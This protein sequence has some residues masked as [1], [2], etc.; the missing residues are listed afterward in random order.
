L[1]VGQIAVAL[2]VLAGASL[3]VKSLLR[4][5]QVDLGFDSARLL[6][7]G[8]ILP[9]SR[10]GNWTADNTR[11]IDAQRRLLER[12]AAIPGVEIV[13]DSFFNEFTLKLTVEARPA[14]PDRRGPSGCQNFRKT[15]EWA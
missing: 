11:Y 12:L 2:V 6:T 14:G 5:Q 3:L 4:M 8:L 1:I 7:A 13:N 15:T 9:P 10:Y